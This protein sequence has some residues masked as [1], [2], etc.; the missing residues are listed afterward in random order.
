MKGA[1]SIIFTADYKVFINET[2]NAGMATAGSGDVLAGM[3]GGL[4]A[5]GLTTEDAAKL[6]VWLH[7]RC[8]DIFQE[9]YCQESL[10]ATG[11]ISNI[12]KAYKELY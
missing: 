1:P 6:G 3:I 9:E 5:Q 12:K 11:L 8:G 4:L 2:G 7:G 10:T